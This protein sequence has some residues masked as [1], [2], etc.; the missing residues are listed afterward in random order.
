MPVLRIATRASQLALWQANFV[1]DSLRSLDP[2]VTVELVHVTTTGDRVQSEPLR[3]FG[4]QGVFTREVQ[5]ALLDGRADIAVHS[6]KDL[7]TVPTAGLELAAVPARAPVADALLLPT[8]HSGP[9]SLATLPRGARIGT[10][11]P[12]RQAQLL[13]IRPDLVCTEVRGNLD[14]RIRKLDAGE[15]EG[16][17]LAVAG[18]S[19]LGW[20]DRI[21][22][23]LEPPT[24]F[25]AAGQGAL[26][27][28]CRHGDEATIRWVSQ[29]EDRQTRLAVDAERAVL[30]TLEAGCHAPVGTWATWK[31]PETLHLEAI[32][33]APDGSE[34]LAAASSM[35]RPLAHN[36][37]VN[38]LDA[39]RELG[40]NVAHLLLKQG[41]SRYLV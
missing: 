7:P 20:S 4:G 41:A 26:G 40:A 13:R 3:Q 36:G 1:A 24:M 6:L 23:I 8:G 17:I 18:L 37:G 35:H 22:L 9:A 28:E 27:L 10:G 16:L 34:T 25:P 21:S 31:T 15:Y 38:A 5:A 14:T 33:I 2:E 19:R 11:S 30:R 12:R 29:L 39:A 32:L